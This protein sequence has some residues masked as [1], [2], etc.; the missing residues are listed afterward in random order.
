[1][2]QY[3]TE[4]DGED[5][6]DIGDVQSGINYASLLDPNISEDNI[7]NVQVPPVSVNTS[8]VKTP[9]K[10]KVDLST[11]DKTIVMLKKVCDAMGVFMTIPMETQV[12][13][14]ATKENIGEDHIIWYV[15]GILQSQSNMI[16]PGV[17]E[18]IGE[19]RA[20]VKQVQTGTANLIRAGGVIKKHSD[21]LAGEIGRAAASV[22]EVFDK[23]M[24]NVAEA[25]AESLKLITDVTSNKISELSLKDHTEKVTDVQPT[26]SPEDLKKTPVV[27]VEIKVPEK[28]VVAEGVGKFVAPTVADASQVIS[29]RKKILTQVGFS[30]AFIARLTDADILAMLP[31]DLVADISKYT[32]TAR[33]KA[34]IKSKAL[35]NL[36]ASSASTSST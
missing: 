18:A 20:E 1:M 2:A 6:S 15:R 35:E 3:N 21:S 9:L 8:E 13:A 14:L 23:S 33:V 10:S 30:Q 34:A 4:S 22:K 16:I 31:S 11:Q 27:K 29:T 24:D 25:V 19:L 7:P 28:P 17:K 5:Y 12:R 32:L 26:I 36:K